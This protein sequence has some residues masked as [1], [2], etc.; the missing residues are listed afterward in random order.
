[1]KITKDDKF[2]YITPGGKFLWVKN[3]SQSSNFSKRE[4]KWHNKYAQGK[5]IN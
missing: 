5:I 2:L 4:A 1:M 3:L